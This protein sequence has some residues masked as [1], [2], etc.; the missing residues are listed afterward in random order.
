MSQRQQHPQHRGVPQQPVRVGPGR[1][2]TP[3]WA[4]VG[5]SYTQDL[6]TRTCTCP[7][8][9]DG[10]YKGQPCKHLLNA[11]QASFFEAVE[12]ARSTDSETLERLLGS[13]KYA[14][15]P[16]V[17]NAVE[18][19]LW[20]RASADQAAAAAAIDELPAWEDEAAL[21]ATFA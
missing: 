16:D 14:D 1:Y 18:M 10:R 8:F 4:E 17:R 21:K 15:R 6:S 7:A 13:S 2:V 9:V 19:V 11:F 12:T 5:K 20:E 3:S